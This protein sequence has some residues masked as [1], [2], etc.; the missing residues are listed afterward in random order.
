MAAPKVIITGFADEGPVSKRAEE[1]LTM[2]Q[3]LG[4]SYYSPRFID[5]GRGV[6]NVMQ[7]TKAELRRLGKLHEEYGVQPSSIG[8]PIGKVKLLDVDDGTHNT[9]VPFEQYIKKDVPR[10]I[11]IAQA[12]GCKLIRGFSF[13]H[14]K[15]S[16]AQD[17]IDESAKRLSQIAK[18]CGKA[19]L[20]FGLEVEAN[21]IGGNGWTEAALHKA[22][23]SPHLV[24]IFDG[25][26]IICQGYTTEECVAQYKAM[27]KGLGWLHIKDYV[28][29]RG[30]KLGYVDEE[31]LKHFVPC[32]DGDSGWETILRDL[33]P[34]LP[35]MT[36]R[37]AKMGVPG[38]FLDLEPHLKGGGQ[39]G[40]F[41]GCDGFGVALRCLTKLLDYVGIEYDLTRYS[42]LKK[43]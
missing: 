1:Q 20:V 40:G 14:P 15:G 23:D 7:L 13:Y 5:L 4:L 28:R 33:K 2:L 39:F 25:A 41:S 36:S 22:V 8:S 9:F 26:N 43:L 12:L 31:M 10:A 32:T 18:L 17:H 21:L 42:D 19:G 30:A 38:V 11:E 16:P 6:K 29:P 27:K 24:L 34:A 37:L 35:R 3:A